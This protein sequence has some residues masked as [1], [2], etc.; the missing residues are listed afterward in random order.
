[1]N[2]VTHKDMISDVHDKHII[3]SSTYLNV[4]CANIT[5]VD[6]IV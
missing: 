4:K 1:M 6:S 3:S 2:V 5:N